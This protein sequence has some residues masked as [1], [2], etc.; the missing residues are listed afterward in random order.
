MVS[1]IRK[2]VQEMAGY[3]P[4]EQIAGA[5]I[6]KLNTNENPYPPAPGVERAL[7]ELDVEVL[8][9]YPNPVSTAVTD[10]LARM[11]GCPPAHVFVGNGSDEVLAL[12]TRAFVENDGTIGYFDPSYSLYPVLADIRDVERKPVPLGDDF[13]WA[14]P[15]GYAAS[16]FF[17]TYPNAPTGLLY[18]RQ[19]I[20]EFCA[21]F[22]G[23]VVIDEAY[24]DFAVENCM[25]LAAEFENVLVT[26]SLSKS[27]S[28]AGLRV[29]YAVGSEPLI[30]ALAK[31]KDSYNLDAVS[32][33]LAMAALQD[34]DHMRGNAETIRRTRTRLSGAL[35]EMGHMV[36]PSEANFV[37][38]RPKGVEA[39][40][41]FETLKARGILIRYFPGERTGEFIRISIG[42]DAEIDKL[43]ECISMICG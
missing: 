24:V 32:Q 18:P 33:T 19:V 42:T 36:Y 29:G 22:A 41:L 15:E 8:R 13:G 39:R 34:L 23:V 4:G 25:E 43:L 11:H 5:G 31:L 37:W 30:G 12:C 2:S 1:L 10:Q 35:T 26:R 6:I 17:L 38:V 40:D 27:F 20:R 3:V 21:G 9:R 28:L 14:M 7:K 16:L